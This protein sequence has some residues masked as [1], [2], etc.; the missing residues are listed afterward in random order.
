MVHNLVGSLVVGATCFSGT[1]MLLKQNHFFDTIHSVLGVLILS[2]TALMGIGGWAIW[3]LTKYSRNTSLK[4]KLASVHKAMGL[5]MYVVSIFTVA[6]GIHDYF[7]N[8]GGGKELLPPL[9]ISFGLLTLIFFEYY[10]QVRHLGHVRLNDPESGLDLIS[11]DDFYNRVN[12]G[13]ELV[14]LDDLVLDVK[15][16][17]DIHSGGRFVI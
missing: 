12:R 3:F 8:N 11:R 9:A 10:H 14:I 6:T 4:M 17:Q 13:E 2:S 16:Y 1:M 5:I 15:N 7:E